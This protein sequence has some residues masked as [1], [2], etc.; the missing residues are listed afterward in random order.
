MNEANLIE[1]YLNAVAEHL[2]ED[3]REDVKKELRANIED[4]LPDDPTEKDVRSVLEKLGNPVRL[5][6][7]YRQTKRYLIG[8]T[9]YDSYISILKLVI[10]IAA[11]VFSFIWVLGNTANPAVDISKV[12]TDFIT[13]FISGIIS[14]AFD[15]ALQAF[16][17]VTVVFVVLE[18]VGLSEGK[19]PFGKKNWSVD[20][21]PEVVLNN[22]S[23]IGRGE[24]V[25]GLIFSVAFTALL[26]F[27]PQV[28]A[29]YGKTGSDMMLI[30][31]LF[32]IERLRP[33]IFFIILLAALQF[34]MCIYKFIVMRWNLPL[35]VANTVNN[36]A[37]SILVF[38]M[39]ND[40]KIINPDFLARFASAVRLP[41]AGFTTSSHTFFSVFI[42]LF[43]IGCAIDSITGFVKSRS[44]NL[45]SVKI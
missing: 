24:S 25:V 31:P 30:T 41:V 1:R 18:R 2:P 17:W 44:L 8:P 40:G 33:Y 43:I 29:W 16:L 36:I 26:V 35:A 23:R 7:E 12:P 6:G 21:L 9:L 28:F 32:D 5:A 15:G 19:L 3:T 11:I 4:M 10:G 42:I 13:H 20:D 22:K 37:S 38:I 14:A 45:P 39:L 27:Q 34:V